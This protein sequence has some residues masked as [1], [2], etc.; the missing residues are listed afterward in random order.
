MPRLAG[1]LLC[2]SIV[3]VNLAAGSL[4]D[5]PAGY[6]TDVARVLSK[7]E[8][9]EIA[10]RC[11]ELDRKHKAQIAVVIVN[12]L[13]SE[14]IEAA[15]LRL[16]RK[17]GIGRRGINDGI[18]ILLAIGDRQSRIEVGLGLESTVTNDVCSSILS[19][20]QPDLVKKQYR[21]AILRALNYLS[22]TTGP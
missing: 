22:E 19:N 2:F 20:I 8:V 6:V 14:L 18:L 16:F 21:I 7:S 13:D 17:W 4:P 1:I 10:S 15:A 5:K 3:V 9:A 12:S 11:A